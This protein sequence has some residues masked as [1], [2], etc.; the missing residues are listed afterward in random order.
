MV[1]NFPTLTPDCPS[2]GQLQDR[3]TLYSAANVVYTDTCHDHMTQRR[4]ESEFKRG[5]RLG[6]YE[7]YSSNIYNMTAGRVPNDFGMAISGNGDVLV[8]MDSRMAQR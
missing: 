1:R 5:G 7:Q 2:S 6:Q 3:G 8:P 4:E